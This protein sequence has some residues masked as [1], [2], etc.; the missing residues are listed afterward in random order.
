MHNFP[1]GKP[2][3]LLGHDLLDRNR[4]FPFRLTN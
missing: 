4:Q 2:S 1:K 3:N